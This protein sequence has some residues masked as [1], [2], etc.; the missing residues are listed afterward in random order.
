MKP[1]KKLLVFTSTFPRWKDDTNPPFVYELSRR[2]TDNFEV[3]VLAPGFPG[4]KD[5]EV[6]EDMRVRR[7]HYFPRK[8]EKLAGSGGILPALAKNRLYY[9]LV[10]F[11]LAGEYAALRKAVRRIQPEVI[12]AHWAVPQGFICSLM[13]GKYSTNY[14]ATVHGADVFGLRSGCFTKAKKTALEKAKAVTAVSSALKKEILGRITSRPEIEVVPM[15]VDSTLFNPG[16]KDASIKSE[17]RVAGPLLL[18]VGRLTEKKGVMYLIEAMPRVIEYDRKTKLMIIGSG[19]LEQE[20]KQAAKDRGIGNNIIFKGPVPNSLLPGYYASADVFAGPSVRAKGGD[21]EGFGLTFVEAGM[22]GCWLV[23]SN[24]GGI[25]DIIRNGINGFL[26][27]EKDADDLA[28][29][30]IKSLRE[31]RSGKPE[32]FLAFDWE[33]T[34]VKYIEILDR[35]ADAGGPL[36]AND[37]SDG[38]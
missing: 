24:V 13:R 34:R 30:I 33:N 21:S 18:F 14:V 26:V 27:R 10:P 5:S 8:Y 4:A 37:K 6:M 9:F 7:F 20:I 36:R 12:H 17:H 32:T 29:K 16:K 31:K 23:G 15:G 1:K 35:A 11:F 3:H 25:A 2:L 19:P 38:M 28:E 22:S